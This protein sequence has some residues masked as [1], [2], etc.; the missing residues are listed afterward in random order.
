MKNNARRGAIAAALTTAGMLTAAPGALAAVTVTYNTNGDFN[1]AITATSDGASDTVIVK[2]GASAN[3]IALQVPGQTP[4]DPDGPSNS[5]CTASGDTVECPR[6]SVRLVG[7]GGDDVFTDTRT[8]GGTA[9]TNTTFEGGDGADKLT[10]GPLGDSFVPGAGA[11]IVRGG[12]LPADPAVEPFK[13]Y[14]RSGGR[15]EDFQREYAS[16]SV[17]YFDHAAGVNVSLDNAA[18]DGSAGEGD[19]IGA[20]I[21]SVSG[22]SQNDVLTAGGASAQLFG[23]QGDDTLT[24]GAGND[25]LVGGNGFNGS[26]GGSDTLSGGAGD[27][28]LYD[29]DEA[30]FRDPVAGEVRLPSG[31]D[32]LN[33]GD[34]NDSLSA[35]LGADDLVGGPGVDSA[36][37]GRSGTTPDNAPADF[38]PAKLGFTI[39][40]DDVAND[41]QTGAGEGDNVHSDIETVETGD[42]DDV[43]TGSAGPNGLFSGDGNDNVTGG[44]GADDIGTGDGDDTIAVQDGITDRVDGGRG[45]DSAS[46]DLGGGQP[47]KADVLFNVETITGVPLPSV[48]DVTKIPV[49]PPNVAP[50]VTVSGLTVKTK[51]FLKKGTFTLKVTTDEP[52]R[53]V[54]DMLGKSRFRAI[55]DLVIGTGRA[56]LG[57]GKRNVK[58]SVGATNLK[59]F[60]RKLRTKA[61]KKKGITLKVRVVATDALGLATTTTK[62]VKVK[63]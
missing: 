7:A 54:A 4:A 41:G 57:T 39:T 2:D 19:D 26:G 42:G 24:G 14:L 12:S 40:Q 16:D 52:A 10:G 22:T 38:V 21:E 27:D 9:V 45:N 37:F 63:A 5:A 28:N 53:V 34:G 51:D 6:G 61:Q 55:G 46:A 59:T 15:A 31:P 60:K 36:G 20:D 3:R 43:L 33:G 58:V 35:E 17:S 18:N 23:A 1:G 8:A 44:G 29:G 49:T 56:P 13:S 30:A 47:D 48:I 32:S 11:D 50:K 62:T 25:D